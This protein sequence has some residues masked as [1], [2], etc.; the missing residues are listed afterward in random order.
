MLFPVVEIFIFLLK[1]YKLL[2][3]ENT[4]EHNTER[5]MSLVW[6]IW[7]APSLPG[8]H[9]ES[10]WEPEGRGSVWHG[11]LTPDCGVHWSDLYPLV[12]F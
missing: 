10:L 9:K 8:T 7:A 11:D 4:E 6:D 3:V 2:V 1:S 5:V 12:C